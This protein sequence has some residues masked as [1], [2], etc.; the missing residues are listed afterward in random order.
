MVRSFALLLQLLALAVAD[1]SGG[2]AARSDVCSL[3]SHRAPRAS[4]RTAEADG[5]AASSSNS[6]VVSTG[7]ALSLMRRFSELVQTLRSGGDRP[8]QMQMHAQSVQELPPA[9]HEVD[10]LATREGLCLYDL[11]GFLSDSIF[12][13][14]RMM[15]KLFFLNNPPVGLHFLEENQF[16]LERLFLERSLARPRWLAPAECKAFIVPYF[17]LREACFDNASSARCRKMAKSLVHIGRFRKPVGKDHFIVAD[18]IEE[19]MRRV[20]SSRHLRDLRLVVARGTA[21]SE[22]REIR[23]PMPTWF[24]YDST[25]D[26]KWPVGFGTGITVESI[27]LDATRCE[28]SETEAETLLAELNASCWG[29][30]FCGLHVHQSRFRAKHGASEC[31]RHLDVKYKCAGPLMGSVTHHGVPVLACNLGPCWIWSDCSKQD[32]DVVV[33]GE[34]GADPSEHKWIQMAGAPGA[35]AG[36]FAVLLSSS[37][38]SGEDDTRNKN[39]SS[40]RLLQEMCLE[41]EDRC[42]SFDYKANREAKRFRFGDEYAA[43][44]SGTFCLIPAGDSQDDIVDDGM[45]TTLSVFDALVLGC[46]PV[47]TGSRAPRALR[48]HLADWE[49]VSVYVPAKKFEQPDFNIVDHLEKLTQSDSSFV[50]RKRVAIGK[51][52]YSLQYSLSEPPAWTERG[53]DAYDHLVRGMILSAAAA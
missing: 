11:E 47:L 51:A 49:S 8:L 22:K 17:A 10:M 9:Q 40:E 34:P 7:G 19:P 26:E 27:E 48:W 23:V 1:S 31:P 42:V 12:E 32:Q 39:K 15:P 6:S 3:F 21:G 35:D 2:G 13:M 4:S 28:T 20:L 38:E 33:Y 50:L 29:R 30:S 37:A 43:T 25:Y 5:V 41:R 24:R 44:M 45:A 18:S 14:T 46:I 36:P 52:A 16:R 53:H